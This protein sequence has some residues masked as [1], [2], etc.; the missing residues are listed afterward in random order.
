MTEPFAQELKLTSPWG[1]VKRI[2]EPAAG[3]QYDHLMF[4]H[5]TQNLFGYVAKARSD[6]SDGFS[7]RGV[8]I[9]RDV[10]EIPIHIHGFTQPR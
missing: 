6:L 4:C 7:L 9:V 5:N 8:Y 2:Q 3:W 10:I 1:L